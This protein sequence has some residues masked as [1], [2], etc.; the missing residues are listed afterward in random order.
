MQEAYEAP[1]CLPV[2][3]K[4]C[5]H[6]YRN[7]ETFNLASSHAFSLHSY[8]I[9]LRT[10]WIHVLWWQ[11]L[12]V[13]SFWKKFTR[14]SLLRHKNDHFNVYF[15]F[16]RSN[17][18]YDALLLAAHDTWV[19]Y[20]YLLCSVFLEL[21]TDKCRKLKRLS[22]SLESLLSRKSYVSNSLVDIPCWTN[23]FLR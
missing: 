9:I 3:T 21:S 23:T 7:N 1:F 11:T 20:K 2:N 8:E 4:E 13:W 16:N 22:M 19:R 5:R 10:T 17:E 6:C 14:C 18:L 12:R 15:P